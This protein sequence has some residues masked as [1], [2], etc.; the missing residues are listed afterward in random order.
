MQ[1]IEDYKLEELLRCPYRFYQKAE[2]PEQ[3]VEWRQLV[4][5][6]MGHVI[7]DYYTL[8]PVSRTT[9]K[10]A[11]LVDQRWTNR[12]YKF[13]SKDHFYQVKRKVMSNLCH[14]L[15]GEY[16]DLFPMMLFEQWETYIPELDLKLSLIFQAVFS[17]AD[18]ASSSYTVQKFILDNDETVITMLF[19][20]INVFCKHTFAELP[21]K[22]EV[23]SIL[24]GQCHT[25]YPSLTTTD[26][27]IDYMRLLRDFVPEAVEVRREIAAA[28]C[29]NC[30]YANGCYTSE[31]QRVKTRALPSNVIS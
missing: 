11:Q 28:E 12:A 25:F 23:F 6:V 4:Q 14:I 16:K 26:Q 10:V 29:R 24:D 17:R 5:Y 3:D 13:D 21:E 27:S 20:M 18:N 9:R 30:P 8:P 19:H 2:R 1:L 22:I 15:G 7:N 31:S